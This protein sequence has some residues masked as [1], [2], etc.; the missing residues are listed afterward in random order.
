M[1][2]VWEF[3]IEVHAKVFGGAKTLIPF[4][5]SSS[6]VTRGGCCLCSLHVPQNIGLFRELRVTVS[7]MS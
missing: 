5:S 2:D 7:F 4:Y 6:L 1:A 3:V